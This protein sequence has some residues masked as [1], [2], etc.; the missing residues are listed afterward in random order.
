MTETNTLRE[1]IKSK[2]PKNTPADKDMQE[3]ETVSC[4]II[5]D[6]N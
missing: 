6:K 3:E 2:T 1:H 4:P 5:C